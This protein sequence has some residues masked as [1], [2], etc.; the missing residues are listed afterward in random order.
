M[1]LMEIANDQMKPTKKI[2]KTQLPSTTINSVL[3]MLS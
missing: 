1:D 2:M 3:N